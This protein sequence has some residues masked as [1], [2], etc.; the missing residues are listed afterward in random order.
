MREE[1]L[2]KKYRHQIEQDALDAPDDVW[3]A[4]AAKLDAENVGSLHLEH[5]SDDDLIN[6][7]WNNISDELDIDAI[8]MIIS[9]D[10]DQDHRII[11]PLYKRKWIVAAVLLFMVG[12]SSLMHIYTSKIPKVQVSNA[13]QNDTISSIATRDTTISLNKLQIIEK[14]PVSFSEDITKSQHLNQ[15]LSKGNP[16]NINTS[17]HPVQLIYQHSPSK[18]ENN[19]SN[20]QYAIQSIH[21]KGVVALSTFYEILTPSSILQDSYRYQYLYNSFNYNSRP[22]SDNSNLLTYSGKDSRW[23]IG[24]ITAIKNTYLMSQKTKNGFNSHNMVRTELSIL[25]D[26]GLCCKYALNQKYIVDASFFLSSASE[27]SYKEYI[28]GEYI[29]KNIELNYLMSELTLKQNSKSGFLSSD[30]IIRRNVAGLYMAHLHSALEETGDKKEIITSKYSS[31]DYGLIIGQEFELKSS[32]PIKI[33]AGVSAKYGL[34]NVYRGDEAVPSQLNRTH[35]AS[36]EFRLGIAY[37]IPAKEGIDH[38]LGFLI[39]K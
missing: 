4:I 11:T 20:N 36:L 1:E 38:Y 7:V 2:F 25:P 6:E 22:P 33:T 24:V 13:I 23:T 18:V 19:D 37:R 27:Q 28:H 3:H 35:N 15:S 39:D 31:L 26:I 29:S 21:P 14:V 12:I 30:K 34:P 17:K 9:N 10:L 8:W 5:Q 16:F 32:G